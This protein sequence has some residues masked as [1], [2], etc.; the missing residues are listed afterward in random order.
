LFACCV[1]SVL[2]LI[3]NIIKGILRE[4]HQ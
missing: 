2:F 1:F 4:P 3:P